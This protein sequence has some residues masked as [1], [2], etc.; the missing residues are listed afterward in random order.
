MG[1]KHQKQAIK[2]IEKDENIVLLTE[3]TAQK[4]LRFLWENKVTLLLLF[5]VL[6]GGVFAA[7]TFYKRSS[8]ESS[9]AAVAID[10]EMLH[11]A[12]E[13][14]V[15]MTTKPMEMALLPG[16]ENF[17]ITGDI[18]SAKVVL[19]GESHHHRRS[20][21]LP[22]L[23]SVSQLKQ[24]AHKKRWSH[25][26]LLEGAKAGE[27]IDCEIDNIPKVKGRVCMGWDSPV[28]IQALAD[29]D[30]YVTA[31]VDLKDSYYSYYEEAG[32]QQV[33]SLFD[34]VLQDLLRQQ[35]DQTLLQQ[36]YELLLK[37]QKE[38][39]PKIQEKIH[40]DFWRANSVNLKVLE[41]IQ[42]NRNKGV[43]YE[44]IFKSFAHLSRDDNA[45]E[46]KK[47]SKILSLQPKSIKNSFSDR[48]KYLIMMLEQMATQQPERDIVVVAGLA[49]LKSFLFDEK[50]AGGRG[51]D[52]KE[53]QEYKS[54]IN[55][56][57]QVL[58][59]NSDERPY[60]FAITRRR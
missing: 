15:V 13:T 10:D 14:D 45:F 1:K 50:F 20:E 52:S 31:M 36:Q 30:F 40:F 26:V 39:S 59:D 48:N 37:K 9:D 2:K 8:A 55:E 7:Y 4:V 32:K 43:S 53:I 24:Q 58:A 60:A 29:L 47:K 12:H 34:K 6:T 27:V 35:N 44:D 33:S 18:Q 57:Q 41:M 25:T 51:F 46:Q 16:C 22:C 28:S 54:T 38:I 11:V 56:I 23:A 21:T 5:L 3:T 17:E 42:S 49:H 19:I